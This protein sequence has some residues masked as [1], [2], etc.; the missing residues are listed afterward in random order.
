M[1]LVK[2]DKIIAGMVLAKDL[3]DA[4]GRLL[5]PK[6]TVLDDVRKEHLGRWG[7]DGVEIEDDSCAGKEPCRASM[8]DYEA[9]EA[10]LTPLFEASNLHF[11]AIRAIFK[12]GVR[13]TAGRIA[14]GWTPPKLEALPYV[15]DGTFEDLF[16]KGEGTVEELVQHE[17]QLTSFPDIYF[18]IRKVLQSP[19]SSSADVAEVVSKDTSLSAKLL[20]LVNSPFYGFPARVDSI[21]R[22]VTIVG[23]NELATLA[24]GISAIKT[25]TKIP[26]ELVDMKSF[27]AHSIGCGVLASRL[28]DEIGQS[29][30]ER[31]FVAGMLHDIGRLVLFRQMPCACMEAL[32]FSRSDKIP[33]YDAEQ[34]VMG[35]DHAVVG[36]LLFK[37]WNLPRSLSQV[38]RFHH[39]P[40][41]CS[42]PLEPALINLADVLAVALGYGSSGSIIIPELSEVTWKTLGIQTRDLVGIVDRAEVE[43]REIVDIFLGGEE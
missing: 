29:G 19:L 27:W 5:I 43:I 7:I 36:T 42:E 3:V 32:I 21:R 10:Y 23:S 24:L 30:L 40:M 22:A 11:S 34:K 1:G 2:T 26:A 9:A 12:L 39:T 28:A 41:R 16:L 38:V 33:L 14:T 37:E 8:E 6:G 31:Y 25:F 4:K 18:R 13:R 20:R 15:N 17:V 35:F